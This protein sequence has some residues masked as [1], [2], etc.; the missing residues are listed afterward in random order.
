MKTEDAIVL[1]IERL[2]TSRGGSTTP[3]ESAEWLLLLAW[4]FGPLAFSSLA[5]RDRPDCAE[6]ARRNA[7]TC[8]TL[9]EFLNEERTDEIIRE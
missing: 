5:P 4:L 9:P 1:E 7:Q 3:P 2:E 6:Y 8:A